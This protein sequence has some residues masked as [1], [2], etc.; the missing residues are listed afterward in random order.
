MENNQAIIKNIPQ[1]L[2]VLLRQSVNISGCYDADENIC[3]L[4]ESLTLD[5][6]AS[7]YAFFIWLEENNKTFGQ[8]VI[9]VWNTF[10]NSSDASLIYQRVVSGNV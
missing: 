1:K 7:V 2:G 6:Y 3:Y 5:E 9:D 8:N 4:E 10:S